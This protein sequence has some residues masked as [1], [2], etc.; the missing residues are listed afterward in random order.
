[1][2][3]ITWKLFSGNYSW[4]SCCGGDNFS[5]AL[6]I[7]LCLD[8]KCIHFKCAAVVKVQQ[9]HSFILP[10]LG[11][12]FNSFILCMQLNSNSHLLQLF[13]G[14]MLTLLEK[15]PDPDLKKFSLKNFKKCG[16]F[17]IR[18]LLTS[19]SLSFI[20]LSSSI[21]VAFDFDL[22]AMAGGVVVLVNADE[23]RQALC[24]PNNP[25][26]SNSWKIVLSRCWSRLR[27]HFE[28]WFAL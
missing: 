28:Y 7:Y 17:F 1:M 4:M 12:C 14:D 20:W 22:S 13:A 8:A 6:F 21:F 15:G 18:L 10:L 5:V 24:V 25:I 3:L 2:I 9:H 16:R 19:F 27:K 11:S 23:L 26:M